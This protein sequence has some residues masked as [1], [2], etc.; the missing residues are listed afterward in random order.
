MYLPSAWIQSIL[1]F[2]TYGFYDN[3][4]VRDQNVESNRNEWR[5]ETDER[6]GEGRGVCMRTK[7][8]EHGNIE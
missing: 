1:V 3:L 8:Q 4:G 6:E 5:M 2:L 7:A